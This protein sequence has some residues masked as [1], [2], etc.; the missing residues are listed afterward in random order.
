MVDHKLPL[1]TNELNQRKNNNWNATLVYRLLRMMADLGVVKLML[2][3]PKD[4]NKN[5]D[6]NS[7]HKRRFQLTGSGLF[8]TKS[9]H[10]RVR[11]VVLHDLGPI[12]Q[13]ASLFLAELIRNDFKIENGFE[14]FTGSSIFDYVDK[15]EN[16]EFSTMFLHALL[17]C[18][19]LFAPSIVAVIGFSPFKTLVDI[20]GGMGTL[21][22]IILE[23]NKQ[24]HG[25]LFDLAYAID[26]A[27]ATKLSEFEQKQINPSRHE[28]VAGNTFELETI[29]QTDS[30]ILNSGLRR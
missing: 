1:P 21:L 11:D 13:K 30:Y 28:F 12:Q 22:A 4:E 2:P 16:E 8:L 19:V 24:L 23:N 20:G 18:S 29:P 26:M 27:E 14:L 10:V 6:I 5:S 25:I 3:H 7:E 17:S 15:K 9:H